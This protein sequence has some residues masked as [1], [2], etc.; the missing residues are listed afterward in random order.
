MYC[1]LQVVAGEV[2]RVEMEQVEEGGQVGFCYNQ[3]LLM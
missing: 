2:A 1:L 3:Q